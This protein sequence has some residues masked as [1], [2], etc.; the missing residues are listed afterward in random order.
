MLRD[1]P[2]SESTNKAIKDR[3][4]GLFLPF[5]DLETSIKYATKI[6]LELL[7]SIEPKHHKVLAVI[8]RWMNF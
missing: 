1:C 4:H 2:K 5:A 6:L 8:A 7:P 3:D